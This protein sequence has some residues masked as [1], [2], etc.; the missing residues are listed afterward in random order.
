MPKTM[1]FDFIKISKYHQ[2]YGLISKQTKACTPRGQR[3]SRTTP[4]ASVRCIEMFFPLSCN[5]YAGFFY[6]LCWS[7]QDPIRT[8]ISNL[9]N[10]GIPSH[11]HG[12]AKTHTRAHT[13][14]IHLSG[15]CIGR[16][17]S[18]TRKHCRRQTLGPA[19][20]PYGIARH[21]IAF[22]IGMEDPIWYFGH[23]W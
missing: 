16:S 6:R 23:K 9:L 11:Y 14:T 17:R 18:P 4:L 5:Q 20:T 10:E 22:D 21:S 7:L 12:C 13:H 8:L 15:R 3:L 2:P 1:K 19:E